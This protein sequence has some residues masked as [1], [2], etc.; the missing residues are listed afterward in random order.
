MGSFSCAKGAYYGR[1]FTVQKCLRFHLKVTTR[2]I[3]EIQVA[4]S[5]NSLRMTNSKLCSFRIETFYAGIAWDDQGSSCL[6]LLL[7]C[8]YTPVISCTKVPQCEAN[9]REKFCQCFCESWVLI[10][11][12]GYIFLYRLFLSGRMR[13]LRVT[14]REGFSFF[15]TK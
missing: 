12:H 4:Y 10:Q 9:E 2:C 13:R 3:L 5:Y 11:A 1:N 7:M 8:A 14:S 15:F 6:D